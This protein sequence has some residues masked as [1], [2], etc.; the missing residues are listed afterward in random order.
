MRLQTS[1][2]LQLAV[3]HDSSLV[4]VPYRAGSGAY[5]YG[6]VRHSEHSMATTS[7][8]TAAVLV[9]MIRNCTLEATKKLLVWSPFNLEEDDTIEGDRDNWSD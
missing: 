1:K 6:L 8:S 9:C 3:N 4:F 2:P 5:M 7:P